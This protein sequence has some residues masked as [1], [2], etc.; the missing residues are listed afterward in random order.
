MFEALVALFQLTPNKAIESLGW[1]KNCLDQGEVVFTPL[2]L[3]NPEGRRVGQGQVEF[4]DDD[5]QKFAHWI[6][7]NLPCSKSSKSLY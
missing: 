4:T 7:A 6:A 3:K 5:D 2:L 1:F